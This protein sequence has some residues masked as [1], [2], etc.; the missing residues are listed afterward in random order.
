[1]FMIWVRAHA[2]F[3]NDA[4]SNHSTLGDKA[5]GQEGEAH[6]LVGS[7]KLQ[8]LTKSGSS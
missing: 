8:P 6:E 2:G 4:S 1:M 3:S 7:G 5:G